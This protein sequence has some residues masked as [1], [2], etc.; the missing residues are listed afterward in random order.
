M[1][2]HERFWAKVSRGEPASCWP[3]RGALSGGYGHFWM[4]GRVTRAHRAA[5]ILA[6][7]PIPEGMEVCH[8]CPGGDN[9]SCVNP[10]HLFLGTHADNMA[11][12]AAKGRADRTRKVR[13]TRHGTATVPESRPR[14]ERNGSAVLTAEQA[15]EVRRQLAAGATQRVVAAAFGIGQAQVSRIKTGR[16]WAHLHVEEP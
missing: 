14:G 2:V 3:W 4:D 6:H 5:W 9:P 12:C 10:A 1:T 16:K 15:L 7:G 8:N 11:D 13:G